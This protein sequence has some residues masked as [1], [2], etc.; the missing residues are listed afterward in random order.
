MTSKTPDSVESN[1]AVF[2]CCQA[3]RAVYQERLAQGKDECSA[4]SGANNAYLNAMPPLHGTRN[5]RN[6]IACIT[7]GSLMGTVDD[8]KCSRLLYAA[9]VAHA[10]RRTRTPKA[11]SGRAEVQ[12]SHSGAI[13][14]PKTA[15][16]EP[17]H[18]TVQVA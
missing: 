12:K 17:P 10:T 15:V 7:Y 3:W 18:G 4:R 5:I 14:A 6:F 9:Q 13:Q 8:R 2:R 16:S 11:K 1:P